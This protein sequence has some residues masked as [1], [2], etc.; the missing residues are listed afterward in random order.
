MNDMRASTSW[1]FHASAKACKNSVLTSAITSGM[2]CSLLLGCNLGFELEQFST[3]SCRGVL[4][5]MEPSG[6]SWLALYERRTGCGDEVCLVN[7]QAVCHHRKTMQEGTSKTDAKDA[8]SVFDLLQQGKC[9]LPVAR[10]PERK[11]AYRLMQ[12]HMAR[13]KRVSHR[14]NQLASRSLSGIP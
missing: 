14:R 9:F 2:T 6:I 13:K 11:A 5:A 7:C 1:R 10:D 12:R 3:G 4:I 8:Y